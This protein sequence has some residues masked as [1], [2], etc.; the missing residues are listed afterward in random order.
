METHAV[1]DQSE[2]LGFLG[3]PSTYGIE[4]RVK[5]IDTHGAAVFLAGQD[6]YKIKRAVRFPFMDF[7]TLDKRARACTRELEVN[8][9]N[10]P[11]VYLG[12]VPITRRSGRLQLGG[13]DE[14]VEWAVHMRRFDEDATLDQ[15]AKRGG[16]SPKLVSA[17][18]H[19]VVKSHERA[20]RLDFD[21]VGALEGIILENASS[22]AENP[23]VFPT[24]RI[25]AL[26]TTS[27]T[28]LQSRGPLLMERRR[29]GYVRR[30]HG[31]LH[32]RNIV[33]LH[34]EPVL[35]DALEF[36]EAMATADVLYDLAFLVMDLW[37]RG[38][39]Q[40]AN[41][42]LNHYLWDSDE[43]QLVGLSAF[44]LF[45]SVRA[46]IRAKVT[47][48]SL[49]QLEGKAWESA[50]QEA[51]RYFSLAEQFLIPV[52]A[53]LV[54]IG[55]LSGTGKSTIAARLAPFVG[56][57]PGA[58]WLRTDVMRKRM[59]EVQETERLPQS[60]YDAAA[61][62]KVYA[63]QRR[64]SALALAST[65]SV[66]VDAVHALPEERQA[67]EILARAAGVAFDGLWLEAPLALRIER[68]EGRRD[69]A[70]DATAEYVRRQAKADLGELSWRRI[71][72]SSEPRAVVRRVL[73]ALGIPIKTTSGAIA[74]RGSARG[75]SSGHEFPNHPPPVC[76]R[77]L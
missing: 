26:R 36:D 63:N 28:L 22:L 45:L 62:A 66:I 18:A 50:L 44:P 57:T 42:V 73:A 37:E 8:R 77:E 43:A 31:D 10:A 54:A 72:A 7:S 15:V 38:F 13:E 27:R 29:S 47:A 75:D 60:G 51:R 6:A 11:G 4:G 41:A 35:F 12:L 64:Q 69:D 5:R 30:C 70:S 67:I 9:D 40:Q 24:E 74:A 1:A 16:L 33:M 46:A 49:S 58:V 17:L 53:R 14:V 34:G 25:E 71:D 19:V 3:K 59:F 65:F 68:V 76:D 55:G 61:S 52:P 56:R 21:S 2:V 20:P 39:H 32:L 48:A 23:E